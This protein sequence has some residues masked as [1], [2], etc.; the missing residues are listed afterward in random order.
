[1]KWIRKITNS[2]VCPCC[3]YKGLEHPPYRN[4]SEVSSARFIDPP[5]E[6][7]FG[8]PS[9]EVCACCGFEFGNDD[10]S[11][12]STP[13]SFDQYLR[14]W[15]ISGCEWFDPTK[16]PMGWNLSEQLKNAG[17]LV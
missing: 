15:V 9:Y 14:E 13:V 16:K 10:N 5:Y 6:S 17:L 11:G 3:G 8:E 12:I 2:F 4:L 7:Y 1:M